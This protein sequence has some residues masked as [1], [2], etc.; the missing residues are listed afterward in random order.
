[1]K[2]NSTAHFDNSG[3]LVDEHEDSELKN[4]ISKNEKIVNVVDISAHNSFFEEIDRN[5]DCF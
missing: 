1:V 4:K 5:F 2:I 3:M